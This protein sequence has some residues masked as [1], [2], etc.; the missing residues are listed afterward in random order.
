MTDNQRRILEML[1]EK[2]IT[3]DEAERLLAVTEK[4]EGRESRETGTVTTSKSKRKYL[5]IMVTPSG[6]QNSGIKAE[7]VNVRVPLTLIRAGMKLRA[8]L[9]PDGADKVNEALRSKGINL[10]VRSIKDEDIE[11]LIEALT[12]LEVD[13]SDE[14]GAKAVRIYVE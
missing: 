4:S 3:I 14:K 13:V 12:D 9:P 1:A 7:I 5:R 11:Q 10:D 2:K 8:F 6:E